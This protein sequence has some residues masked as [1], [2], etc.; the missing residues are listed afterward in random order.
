I[1]C[2]NEARTLEATL[3][4]LPHR[5]PGFDSVVWLVVDDGSTDGTSEVARRCGVDR[6]VRLPHR[7]GLAN[8]FRTALRASLDA[9]ADIVVNTDG[10]N[11]YD[12][13]GVA[14]L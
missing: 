3:R 8:A 12:G 9:G 11:Q 1:P 2:F 13:R 5:L 14:S 4:D 7:R 6:I 10:D